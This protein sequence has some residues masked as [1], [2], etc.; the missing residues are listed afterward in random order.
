MRAPVVA[1]AVEGDESVFEA[2]DIVFQVGT[3]GVRDVV[4]FVVQAETLITAARQAGFFQHC[5]YLGC[6]AKV[7]NAVA[8]SRVESTP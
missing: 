2:D 8:E 5:P 3:V 1:Q 4:E 7:L 6:H